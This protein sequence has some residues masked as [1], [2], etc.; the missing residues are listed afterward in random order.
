LSVGQSDFGH[1]SSLFVGELHTRFRPLSILR[2]Q[3]VMG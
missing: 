3:A 1:E 2:Q